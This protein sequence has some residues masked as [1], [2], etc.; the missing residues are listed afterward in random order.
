MA[1]IVTKLPIPSNEKGVP[2]GVATLD[3]V[4]GYIP[5]SQIDPSIGGQGDVL[6]VNNID[7]DNQGNVDITTNDIPELN[8]LY[9]TQQRFTTAPIFDKRCWAKQWVHDCT[10]HGSFTRLRK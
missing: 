7:P 9:Y 2:G 5:L 1:I 4:T 3:P 10:R 6:S 8:N